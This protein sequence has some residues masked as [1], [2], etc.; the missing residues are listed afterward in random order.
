[1]PIIDKAQEFIY[2]SLQYVLK[3]VFNNKIHPCLYLVTRGTQ[4]LS[5]EK[6]IQVQHSALW[7]LGRTFA[8]EYPTLKFKNIDLPFEDSI[9]YSGFL[10]QDLNSLETES[11]IV[12]RNGKRF[13]A[14]L[15]LHDSIDESLD[16][17]H[18]DKVYLITGGLGG[19]GLKIAQLLLN[20]GAQKLVLIGRKAQIQDEYSYKKLLNSRALI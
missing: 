6:N 1:M 7:G 14:R 12:Y 2:L 10:Y 16:C 19:I 4:L 15:K 9:D 11:N 17:C 8:L 13:V 20:K 18:P 3:A 5:I